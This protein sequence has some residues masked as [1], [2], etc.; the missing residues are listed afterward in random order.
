MD[1]QLGDSED[2]LDF[3][4]ELRYGGAE[5][6]LEDSGEGAEDE[7]LAVVAVV[8]PV[9]AAPAEVVA[10]PEPVLPALPEKV[11]AA[12]AKAKSGSVLKFRDK[13][14]AEDVQ[15]HLN[16]SNPWNLRVVVQPRLGTRFLLISR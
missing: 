12:L 1:G 9:V 3:Q 16:L 6:D 15:C 14:D 13:Q 8:A 10:P 7:T 4:S 5:F 2:V 11:A